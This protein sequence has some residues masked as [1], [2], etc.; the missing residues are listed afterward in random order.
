MNFVIIEPSKKN[1]IKNNEINAL[2]EIISLLDK[3]NYKMS[4]SKITNINNYEK[5][6]VETINQIKIAN[7]FKEL[8]NK[9]S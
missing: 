1:T 2:N 7:E 8:I 6:F 4:Y 5:Y 3:K 9:I